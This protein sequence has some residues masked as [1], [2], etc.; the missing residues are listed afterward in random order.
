MNDFDKVVNGATALL[1]LKAAPF[2]SDL[3]VLAY[4]AGI[5]S[6]PTRSLFPMFRDALTLSK[7]RHEIGQWCVAELNGSIV[8][9][10]PII[11]EHD[12]LVS[13]I[14]DADKEVSAPIEELSKELALESFKNKVVA[15]FNNSSRRDLMDKVLLFYSRN[16]KALN[17]S[18]PN[19]V[20]CLLEEATMNSST[21]IG[22]KQLGRALFNHFNLFD[23]D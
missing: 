3:S 2:R 20:A 11:L 12:C 16:F 22:K 7:V 10:N 14:G 9:F 1:K 17:L 18:L 19:D 15:L 21:P 8:Q 4:R 23:P 5:S 13:Q 6:T